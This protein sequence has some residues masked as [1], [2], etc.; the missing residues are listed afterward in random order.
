MIQSFLEKGE[1]SQKINID[2][3]KKLFAE[4]QTLM[5]EYCE[6][7]QSNAPIEEIKEKIAQ[8]HETYLDINEELKALYQEI[9]IIKNDE[10]LLKLLLLQHDKILKALKTY[11]KPLLKILLSPV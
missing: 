1:K 3:L 7:L 11:L 6:L 5:A 10:T 4:K 2:L 8:I 9:M